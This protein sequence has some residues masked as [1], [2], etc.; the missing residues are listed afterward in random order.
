MQDETHSSLV[1]VVLWLVL[2][3]VTFA[4]AAVWADAGPAGSDR[5]LSSAA[6]LASFVVLAAT[7]TSFWR[8]HPLGLATCIALVLI[9]AGALIGLVTESFGV[10]ETAIFLCA[11]AAIGYVIWRY[12]ADA[13]LED[14]V[15]GCDYVCDVRAVHLSWD[16]EQPE[17]CVQF[18]VQ[19]I[20][21]DVA[22]IELQLQVPPRRG[23]TGVQFKHAQKLQP[24][25]AGTIE[26]TLPRLATRSTACG[27]SVRVRHS[28]AF[29]RRLFVEPR[30]P[31][32]VGPRV[33]SGSSPW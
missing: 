14:Q 11:S 4:L 12:V 23:H 3:P 9:P 27:V 7:T 25:E 8:V 1:L 28:K 31:F 6:A 10:I 13:T 33:F 32:P 16:E 5:M 17:Q 15:T 18:Q 26:F 19:N 30:R 22:T 29:A 21:N 20:R 24:G 2:A